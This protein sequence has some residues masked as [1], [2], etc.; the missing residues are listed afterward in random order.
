MFRRL[1]GAALLAAAWSSASAANWPLEIID[2][3][4]EAKIVVYVNESDIERSPAWDPATGTPPFKLA[5]VLDAIARWEKRN[6]KSG[7]YDIEK[8]ELK[9]I[10]HHEKQGRW[11]YLVQ[12]REPGDS[13]RRHHYVAVLLNGVT[14]AA[15]E[16]PASYK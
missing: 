8:I 14:A 16:E 12:L 2:H 5:D 10:S 1:I 3:L 6:A 7:D 15:I 11:Y 4:D 9:R 13:K